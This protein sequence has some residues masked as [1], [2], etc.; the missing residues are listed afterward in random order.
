M[1]GN[2]NPTTTPGDGLLEDAPPRPTWPRQGRGSSLTCAGRPISCRLEG[3]RV[4]PTS[5]RPGLAR[6]PQ[7]ATGNNN[8]SFPGMKGSSTLFPSIS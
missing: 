8:T 6:A 7:P 5:R 1:H 4:Q 3:R 2:V